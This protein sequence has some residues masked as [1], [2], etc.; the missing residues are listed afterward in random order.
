MWKHLCEHSVKAVNTVPS[1]TTATLQALTR[2]CFLAAQPAPLPQPAQ[3]MQPTP[4]A[5]ATPATQMNQ[6]PAV[7]TTPAVQSNALA[8]M[9]V[10]SYATPVQPQR[11]GHAC[12]ASRCLVQEI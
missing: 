4:T 3:H 2:H 9:P 10:T 8:P 11:S 12:M 5:P 1:D 7:P 6:V